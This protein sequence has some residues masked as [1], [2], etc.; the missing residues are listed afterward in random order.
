MA[1]DQE[2]TTTEILKELMSKVVVIEQKFRRV[3]TTQLREMVDE[4]NLVMATARM[5]L[6]LDR[7]A[8][9]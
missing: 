5:I 7:R 8:M 4:S 3:L 6:C 9:K 1:E 2:K